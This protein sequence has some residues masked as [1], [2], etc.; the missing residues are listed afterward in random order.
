[1]IINV[2]PLINVVSELIEVCCEILSEVSQ[3][4]LIDDL[5]P[6]VSIYK[7]TQ[8][9]LLVDGCCGDCG[10]VE[11]VMIVDGL[12]AHILFGRNQL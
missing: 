8:F 9:V 12:L 3:Q 1:M 6:D 7:A 11:A 2:P 5:I 4:I 10:K